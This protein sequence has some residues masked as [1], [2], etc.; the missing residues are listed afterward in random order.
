VL[1]DLHAS[2]E[3]LRFLSHTV[4]ASNLC[5]VAPD[6]GGAPMARHYSKELKCDLAVADK[7][8]NYAQASEIDSIRLVGDVAGKQ[9]IVPDDMVATG[10]TLINTCRL[11]REK[12]AA[13]VY[14]VCSHPFFNGPAVDRLDRAY[15]DGLFRMVVGD[16]CRLA[17]P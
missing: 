6:T 2:A 7:V 1:E 11:V 8:R 9:V 13:E 17:W 14:V 15:E 12:G 16:R 4:A 3:I 5:V 10:G